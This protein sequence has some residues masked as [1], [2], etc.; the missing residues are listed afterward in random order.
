MPLSNYSFFTYDKTWHRIFD[1][2][3]SAVLVILTSKCTSTLNGVFM[4][5]NTKNEI[6]ES[7]TNNMI[8]KIEAGEVLPWNCPWTKTADSAFPYNWENKN[9]YNGI[10]ILILWITM[11]DNDYSSAGWL[12]FK[13]AK[14]LGGKIK[15]GEKGTRCVFYSPV[16]VKDDSEPDGKRSYNCMK[17]FTV[18][19]VQ[20]I[21]G[22]EGV[23]TPEKQSFSEHEI[24]PVFSKMV[25][26]YCENTGVKITYGGNTACYSP[27]TDNVRL[28]VSFKDGDGFIETCGHELIH[29]TG[30]KTRLNRFKD[31][32]KNTS[33]KNEDYAT[34]EVITELATAFLCAELGVTSTINNHVSYV[35]SYLKQLKSDPNWILKASAQASTAFQFFKDNAKNIKIDNLKAA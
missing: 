6:A 8:A 24:M 32:T 17:W 4:K 1:V 9:Q 26:R 29:S 2:I 10:N 5:H 31:S 22:L 16:V 25:D 13:Q 23:I 34:E 14:S 11:M 21:E 19:N 7:I 20:Q 27:L 15:K 33:Y 12:T 28:P 18:F 35:A 30:H 3:T